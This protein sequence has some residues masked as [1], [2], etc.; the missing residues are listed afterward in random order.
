MIEL[1]PVKSIM[2]LPLLGSVAAG[3]RTIRFLFGINIYRQQATSFSVLAGVGIVIA[4]STLRG[5]HVLRDS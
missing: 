4:Q 2:P 1:F 5:L 3:H